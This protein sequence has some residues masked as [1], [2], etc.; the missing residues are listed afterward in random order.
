MKSL[1]W[2]SVEAGAVFAALAR[3]CEAGIV[4]V[5]FRSGDRAG[6]LLSG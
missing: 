2:K 6:V 5:V 4:L 3:G 1:Q